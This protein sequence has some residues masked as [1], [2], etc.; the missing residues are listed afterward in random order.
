[1]SGNIFI[2]NDSNIGINKVLCHQLRGSIQVIMKT[3]GSHWR[4]MNLLRVVWFFP[5]SYQR[6]FLSYWF[7]V[8]YRTHS[9]QV[10]FS[11]HQWFYYSLQISQS[12]FYIYLLGKLLLSV[13]CLRFNIVHCRKKPCICNISCNQM[14]NLSRVA[15]DKRI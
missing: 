6:C 3:K 10:T 2:S 13:N 11:S 5:A 12:L 15:F 1:M 7:M 14:F 8:A 9:V 4:S